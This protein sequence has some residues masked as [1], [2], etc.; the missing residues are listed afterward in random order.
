M[1]TKLNPILINRAV[2]IYATTP[3]VQHK[4]VADELGINP[5]TLKKLRS[6]EISGNKSMII[7]W[8]PMRV[9]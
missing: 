3:N 2:D 5:K 7:L 9:K 6:D 4:D 8:S 1:E